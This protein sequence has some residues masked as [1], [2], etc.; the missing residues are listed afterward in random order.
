MLNLI[1]DLDGVL[2][3]TEKYYIQYWME[4]AQSFGYPFTREMALSFRSLDHELS[5]KQFHDYFGP[6]ADVE[7]VREKRI[8]LMSNI[9]VEPKPYAKEIAE[10]V[11]EHNIPCCICTAS[12]VEKA[13]RYLGYAGLG[14]LFP[15][16]I[17]AKGVAHGKPYPD[18]YINACAKLGIEPKDALCVEDSPNG[19]RSAIAAGCKAVFCVDLTEATPEIQEKAFAVIHSLEELPDILKTLF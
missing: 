3:D 1:F 11:R 10:F 5:Q 7:A 9:K 4:A 14:G 16:I 17:S 2:I 6:E 13:T 19:F 12:S 8:S 15:N 18:P